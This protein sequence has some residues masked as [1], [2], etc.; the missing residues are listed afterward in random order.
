MIKL[1]SQKGNFIK[2]WTTESD[3]NL[4]SLTQN[5]CA[6]QLPT[7]LCETQ[8]RWRGMETKKETKNLEH[9]SVREHESMRK[10]F[11]EKQK[12]SKVTLNTRKNAEK[13]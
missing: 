5:L 7:G 8:R 12:H 6:S 1:R 10:P 2:C 3:L 9:G 4:G 11:Q 13:I